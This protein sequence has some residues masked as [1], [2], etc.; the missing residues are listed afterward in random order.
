MEIPA[1]SAV[2][3]STDCILS[4]QRATQIVVSISIHR[5]FDGLHTRIIHLLSISS[6]FNALLKML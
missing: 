1:R 4:R 2:L 3:S 6:S 5:P